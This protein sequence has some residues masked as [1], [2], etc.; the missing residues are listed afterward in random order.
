MISPNIVMPTVEIGGGA[1]SLFSFGFKAKAPEGKEGEVT[2][3]E[4]CGVGDAN[5]N[6][7]P[8][9]DI[10]GVCPLNELRSWPKCEIFYPRSLCW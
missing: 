1:V 4:H 2:P 6:A 5:D 8:D 7:D 3:R 9:E 10:H